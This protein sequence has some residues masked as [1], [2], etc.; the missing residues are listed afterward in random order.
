MNSGMWYLLLAH[1]TG[2][3]DTFLYNSISEKFLS[4][5]HH[6]NNIIP[7]MIYELEIH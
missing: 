5:L 7:A 1:G 3:Y 2:T 6:S 4:L